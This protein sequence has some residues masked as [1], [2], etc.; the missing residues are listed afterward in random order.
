MVIDKPTVHA[1]NGA[2]YTAPAPEGH[3]TLLRSPH[4]LKS[5]GDPDAMMWG[6]N[7]GLDNLKLVGNPAGVCFLSA[8]SFVDYLQK[9]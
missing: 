5:H 1:G 8:K 9:V 2:L 6:A 7:N 3:R 4:G